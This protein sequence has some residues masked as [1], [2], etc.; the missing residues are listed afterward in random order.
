ME[1]PSASRISRIVPEPIGKHIWSY[2]YKMVLCEL[3]L[4]TRGISERLNNI[5]KYGDQQKGSIKNVAYSVGEDSYFEWYIS[6]LPYD[7][8][9]PISNLLEFASQGSVAV[10]QQVCVEGRTRTT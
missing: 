6:A 5:P 2:V 4:K 1:Q 9:Y 3:E 10:C 7:G 8:P